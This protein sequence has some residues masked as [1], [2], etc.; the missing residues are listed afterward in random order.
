MGIDQRAQKTVKSRKYLLEKK[1]DGIYLSIKEGELLF[2]LTLEQVCQDLAKRRIPFDQEVIR[3][4]FTEATGLPVKISALSEGYNDQTG[5]AVLLSTDQI[6]A[7]LQVIPFLNGSV[8]GENELLAV[9]EQASIK[10]GIKR[11]VIAQIVAAQEEFN[12][13]LIAEGEPC[14]QGENAYLIFHFNTKGIDVK[15]QELSDGSVDF[16][17]L[18]LIQT[19]EA[20]AVLVE[21]IP[22]K[23]GKNGLTVCGEERKAL[24]GKD[25][26]LPAGQ[27]TQATAE[28][29]KLVAMKPGHVVYINQ[30]VSVLPTYEV[31][32][33]VDFNTGN[34]KFPGNVIVYGN[35]RNN[36]EVE[37]TGDV[38]IH[39][40][41]EGTVKTNGNLQIK[42]GIVRG[43]AYALGSIFARYIENGYVKA[44]ANVVVTDAIMHSTTKA[45]QKVAIGGKKGLLVG[46]SCA[47]GE[48]IRAK[49]I[50]SNLGTSTIVEVGVL[51]EIRLEY[52]E[53]VRKLATHQEDL[54]KTALIIKTL[55]EMKQ[56]T[57]ELPLNKRDMFVKSR[58]LQY[59]LQQEME[60]MKDRKNEL[61]MMFY[62]MEKARIYVEGQ[63]FSGVTITMGKA[64]YNVNDEMRRVMFYL[65]G[66]DIKFGPL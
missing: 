42:K 35:V 39:G 62:N 36:F 60:T 38:E 47:A 22:P 65:E 45:G 66:L 40:N 12:E 19:V 57:G 27:N 15:P 61:E 8:V 55:Q 26:R 14:L 59:Q 1:P 63:I 46:G 29:T 2:P 32:G 58:R 20:G 52:K 28:N 23:A 56:K 41:L 51:P 3:K 17:N 13:W 31:R 6:S 11:D 5:L 4:A 30:K 33:D 7:Y 21:R 9:L 44:D 34:I 18:N 53:I 37:A 50:G 16:Y 43:K 48:E 24:P 10:V 49:F 54:N 25:V 64:V